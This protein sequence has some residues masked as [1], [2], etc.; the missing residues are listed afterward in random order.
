M[1]NLNRSAPTLIQ[2]GEGLILLPGTQFFADLMV[3]GRAPVALHRATS[4]KKEE[5]VWSCGAGERK[6]EQLQRGLQ[7]DAGRPWSLQSSIF[8]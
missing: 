5:E 7:S 1:A 3:A 4:K 8:R 2:A 6:V